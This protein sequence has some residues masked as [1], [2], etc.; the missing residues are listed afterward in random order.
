[1]Q[2]KV[3]FHNCFYILFSMHFFFCKNMFLSLFSNMQSKNSTIFW[4]NCNTPEKQKIFNKK[5]KNFF[6]HFS[7][8]YLIINSMQ[9]FLFCIMKTLN[10]NMMSSWVEKKMKFA[11]WK[12]LINFFI[13]FE[14]KLTWGHMWGND[15]IECSIINTSSPFSFENPHSPHNIHFLSISLQGCR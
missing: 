8:V 1:M 13:L 7:V 6:F 9:N 10:A 5:L 14:G 15:C 11:N 4:V 12:E 2:K 3:K